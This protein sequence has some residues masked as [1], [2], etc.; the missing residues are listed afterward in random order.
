MLS[1][2]VVLCGFRHDSVGS[3]H[4]DQSEWQLYP[5]WLHDDVS[6]SVPNQPHLSSNMTHFNHPNTVITLADH[7]GRFA[8]HLLG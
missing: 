1:S 4:D 2:L 8:L 6:L 5:S 7:A 3:V